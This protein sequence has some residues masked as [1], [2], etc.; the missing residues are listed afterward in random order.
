MASQRAHLG[1]EAV[2]GAR[3]I[4]YNIMGGVISSS[5]LCDSCSPNCLLQS[6][7]GSMIGS[8]SSRLKVAMVMKSLPLGKSVF[9]SLEI[10]S[11]EYW[12]PLVLV[13]W[14]YGRAGWWPSDWGFPEA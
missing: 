8:I 10:L 12:G 3:D 7:A 13:V 4:A 9:M 2:P 1:F 14:E 5:S 6:G 11:V